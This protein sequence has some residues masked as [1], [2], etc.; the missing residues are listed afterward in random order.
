MT[1]ISRR[2]VIQAVLASV[3]SVAI[4]NLSF[5]QEAAQAHILFGYPPG[6][7]GHAVCRAVAEKLTGPYA[8]SAIVD[9]VIVTW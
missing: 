7:A 2:A 4:P 3:G 1:V 5:A 9:P 8:K 6:G